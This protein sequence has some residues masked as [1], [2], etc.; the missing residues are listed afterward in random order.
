MSFSAVTTHFPDPTLLYPSQ[1]E[2]LS[3]LPFH[4]LFPADCP[5]SPAHAATSGS[6]GWHDL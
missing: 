4:V 6:G 2:K 3:L 1:N 5:V